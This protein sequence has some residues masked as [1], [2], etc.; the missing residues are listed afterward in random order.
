MAPIWKKIVTRDYWR[1]LPGK[2]WRATCRRLIAVLEFRLKDW[3]YEQAYPRDRY[4][5][6]SEGDRYDRLVT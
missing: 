1:S 4:D 3:L 2:A 5:I 6:V